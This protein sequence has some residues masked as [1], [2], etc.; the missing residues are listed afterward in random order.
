VN[1]NVIRFFQLQPQLLP[2]LGNNFT[3]HAV[4]HSDQNVI[5]QEI[6]SFV[7]KSNS[8]PLQLLNET[9]GVFIPHNITLSNLFLTVYGLLELP[10]SSGV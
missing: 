4:L 6:I 2:S 8:S 5:S 9:F 10:G 3:L 1:F 7:S